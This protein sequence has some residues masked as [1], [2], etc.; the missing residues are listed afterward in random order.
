VKG[1]REVQRLGA[2]GWREE[3]APV[4]VPEVREGWVE[5]QVEW[6]VEEKGWHW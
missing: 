3:E 6:R 2:Q 1:W 5:G 4:A